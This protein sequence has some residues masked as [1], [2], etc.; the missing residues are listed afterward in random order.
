MAPMASLFSIVP[1]SPIDHHRQRWL[2]TVI[3]CSHGS[4]LIKL[5]PMVPFGEI[6]P[7]GS[8]MPCISIVT[9]GAYVAIG[10][11]ALSPL[12]RQ[13][14]SIVSNRSSLSIGSSLSNGS[15]LSLF[16]QVASLAPLTI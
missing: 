6:G 13:W 16:V 1:S 9:D 3:I 12:D 8:P 14:I 11:T 15:I 7:I 5:A 2:T 10:A 4:P